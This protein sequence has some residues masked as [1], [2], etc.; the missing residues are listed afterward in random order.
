MK[1]R[2][3]RGIDLVFFN[4]LIANITSLQLYNLDDGPYHWYLNPIM[5]KS[6]WS[7]NHNYTFVCIP[8]TSPPSTLLFSA[9]D[10]CSLLFWSLIYREYFDRTWKRHCKSYV[11]TLFYLVIKFYV[12]YFILSTCSICNKYMKWRSPK[13]FLVL[14]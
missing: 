8:F 4:Q 3:L 6:S 9:L 1:G 10:F 13:F 2:N 11:N 5:F 14:C 7:C 12:L